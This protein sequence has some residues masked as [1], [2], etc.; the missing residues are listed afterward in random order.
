MSA[1]ENMGPPFVDKEVILSEG[2]GGTKTLLFYSDNTLELKGPDARDMISSTPGHW[3]S[4]PSDPNRV[5][6][7]VGG[8]KSEYRIK[9]TEG[10]FRAEPP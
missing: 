7:E 9:E 4:D 8:E 5:T 3:H 10:K 6:V 1:S 2:R